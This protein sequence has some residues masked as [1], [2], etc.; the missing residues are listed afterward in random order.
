M[1]NL[2]RF[3]RAS[4]TF[5]ESRSNSPELQVHKI[6]RRRQD[7]NL[8]HAMRGDLANRCHTIRRRLQFGGR[9]RT[10]TRKRQCAVVFKTTA[11]PVRLPFLKNLFPLEMAG[12]LRFELRISILE[13]DGLPV[14]LRPCIAL[15]KSEFLGEVFSAVRE[16]NQICD[17]LCKASLHIFWCMW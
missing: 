15:H 2:A 8:A 11:L 17:F 3:E 9:D 6:W 12:T 10:R 16:M 14:S 4:S 1:V 13:T 7:L 5:A